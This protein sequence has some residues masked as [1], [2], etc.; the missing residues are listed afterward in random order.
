MKVLT[1]HMMNTGD[2]YMFWKIVR[3]ALWR[4]QH[5]GESA[6]IKLSEAGFLG[7]WLLHLCCYRQHCHETL[8]PDYLSEEDGMELWPRQ[9]RRRKIIP[10][11]WSLFWA[12]VVPARPLPP[13]SRLRWFSSQFLP[14]S[15]ILSFWD[16]YKRSNGCIYLSGIFLFFCV[17][18]LALKTL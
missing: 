5:S 3:E 17:C 6:W 13:S 16:F 2:G 4:L 9:H 18:D 14:F 1:N 12:K 15:R 7:K 8:I 10:P 11:N